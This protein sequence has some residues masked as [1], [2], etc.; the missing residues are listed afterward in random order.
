MIL[1][2]TTGCVG[3]VEDAATP[4]TEFVDPTRNEFQFKGIV[5]SRA[6]SNSKVEL[7][8]VPTFGT[9]DYEYFLHPNGEEGIK[10]NMEDLEESIKGR[11]AYT[12][13]GLEINQLYKFKISAQKIDGGD[14]SM[15][16]NEVVVSTFPNWTANFE[17]VQNV[18]LVPGQSD[19]KVKVTWYNPTFIG[20]LDPQSVD[21]VFY[22]LAIIR[23]ADGGEN[24]KSDLGSTDIIYRRIPSNKSSFLSVSTPPTDFIVDGLDADTEYYFRLRAIHKSWFTDYE[25]KGGSKDLPV[26]DDVVSF[27][28]ELNTRLFKIKTDDSLDPATFVKNSLKV[29]RPD[30]IL[31][32]T[33]LDVAWFQA[34]GL[35]KAY[36]LFY[37]KFIPVDPTDA[38]NEVRIADLLD[39]QYFADFDTNS[40]VCEEKPVDGWGCIEL[41]TDVTSY[42]IENLEEFNYYQVRIAVCLDIA[43]SVTENMPSS[44]IISD[45]A[46]NRTEA[47]LAPFAGIDFINHPQDAD[48]IDPDVSIT[49]DFDPPALSKGYADT[50]T[51]HCLDPVQVDA[52]VALSTS[53]KMSNTMP[54]QAIDAGVGNCDGINFTANN[55]QLDTDT[56]QVTVSGLNDVSDGYPNSRYCFA[57]APSIELRPEQKFLDQSNWVVR[58]INP[59]IQVPTL[60][61]FAGIKGACGLN[62]DQA[63]VNWDIPSGGIF[64]G[65]RVM[66]MVKNGGATLDY[67]YMTDNV[68]VD[69]IEIPGVSPVASLQ[70]DYEIST[71]ITDTTQTSFTITDLLPGRT[72]EVAVLASVTTQK[73]TPDEKTIYSEY[74]AGVV[75][76]DVPLPQARFNEWTRIFA[77]GP[78][79]DGL[80]PKINPY[81]QYEDDAHEWESLN[82]D[83]IPYEVNMDLSSKLPGKGGSGVIDYTDKIFAIPPGNYNAMLNPADAGELKEDNFEF[84]TVIDGRPG[85]FLGALGT[86]YASR[87]GI[88]SLA[89]KD[90][91]LEFADANFK[92]GQDVEEDKNLDGDYADATNR[93][94]RAYG[95][96]VYRSHDNKK[97]WIEVTDKSGLLHAA[98]Y[99]YYEGQPTNTKTGVRMV[100]FTDYSVEYERSLDKYEYARTYW[101]KIVPVFDDMELPQYADDVVGNYAHNT[102]R[103]TLPPANMA[104]VHRMM[105]NRRGCQELGKTM[106]KTG[107]TKNAHYA[108]Q[109]NGVGSKPNPENK[110][111]AIDETYFD[112]GGDLLVDRYELGCN[113]TRGNKVPD[114]TTGRSYIDLT[115]ENDQGDTNL[116]SS[117]VHFKGKSLVG[118][119]FVGCASKRLSSQ[120]N[121]GGG[122]SDY[123][124]NFPNHTR[125]GWQ[126]VIWGDC[127][128]DYD[129]PIGVKVWPETT[130]GACPTN[131][132][133]DESGKTT[134]TKMGLYDYFKKTSSTAEANCNKTVAQSVADKQ[135]HTYEALANLGWQRHY[136]PQ[137]EHLA[138]MKSNQPITAGDG[139]NIPEP[140]PN[141]GIYKNY[142]KPQQCFINLASIGNHD[143][144]GGAPAND[145]T[146]SDSATDYWRSRWIGTS[147]NN[148]DGTIA[149]NLKKT[150]AKHLFEMTVDDLKIDSELYNTSEFKWPNAGAVEDPA[151][152]A[153]RT[154]YVG[155]TKVGEIFSSNSAHLPPLNGYYR[156]EAQ[157]LC[158]IREVKTGVSD[159]MTFTAAGAAKPKRL[160]RKTEFHVAAAWP[161][162]QM[163]D[164]DG[165]DYSYTATDISSLESRV[166]GTGCNNSNVLN[167]NF[168]ADFN[169]N[170]RYSSNTALINPLASTYFLSGSSQAFDGHINRAHSGNC[171]SKYG[172]QDLVG[173]L[174]EVTPE[175]LVC[176]YSVDEMK[177]GPLTGYFKA[178][179][180]T[181]DLAAA[182]DITKSTTNSGANWQTNSNYA[183]EYDVGLLYTGCRNT[184]SNQLNTFI[185]ESDCGQNFNGIMTGGESWRY[186]DKILKDA[187]IMWYVW[188]PLLNAGAGDWALDLAKSS[189]DVGG[190]NQLWWIPSLNS[191]FCSVTDRDSYLYK[192]KGTFRDLS[193]DM[194]FPT[195]LFSGALNASMLTF[196]NPYNDDDFFDMYRDGDG[197]FMNFGP[198][199]QMV[200]LGFE[201]SL[202]ISN[203]GGASAPTSDQG[204][205]KYFNP[206]VGFPLGCGSETPPAGGGCGDSEDNKDFGITRGATSIVSD[207]FVGNSQI[208]NKGLNGISYSTLVDASAS[209]DGFYTKTINSKN[210]SNGNPGEHQV[211][212]SFRVEERTYDM[213][214]GVFRTL[215]KIVVNRINWY[216]QIFDSADPDSLN[217]ISALGTLGDDNI[218]IDVEFTEAQFDIQRGTSLTMN[219]GGAYN[220]TSAGRYTSNINQT[221]TTE[222]SGSIRCVVRINEE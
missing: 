196:P 96:R 19:T 25:N 45:K 35:F 175:R 32:F 185:K 26:N 77:I 16:E 146:I 101:Y 118:N 68:G 52:G 108:C 41:G 195:Q 71:I 190:K 143:A 151:M 74:N 5:A 12:V 160:I 206:V 136:T 88:V 192:Q 86:D 95:Y 144:T 22:E 129:E 162:N 27:A 137:G 42:R 219:V 171:I 57:L 47:D 59:E 106:I 75:K 127:S 33:S 124:G 132:S 214:G 116:V 87:N 9:D 81:H 43:C 115:L 213:G 189:T 134:W 210:G 21:P 218:D 165:T 15:S 208:Y 181:F 110:L 179:G 156:D 53:T 154:R 61:E 157:K 128:Y 38:A 188:D 158:N 60:E 90:V 24:L 178:G 10:L 121:P 46:Y 79:I 100:F 67:D 139:N 40:T 73:G 69:S 180:A 18:A 92:N 123:T 58:C 133:G 176:D 13:R 44:A 76:C 150:N 222:T 63:T 138:V 7:E 212:D 203:K 174:H 202:Y 166:I 83:G 55:G 211:I 14:E 215:E 91:D 17:G 119:N 205:G 51:L 204:V 11:L 186:L 216:D 28:R 221:T 29:E 84:S 161:E 72:Y 167:T 199:H 31:A 78:K 85:M 125:Y 4:S 117:L 37:K 66:W 93:S 170:D 30:G 147:I 200:G 2:V 194:F 23:L 105:A 220:E 20:T 140:G 54:F 89:W 120:F 163:I 131:A 149:G 169:L 197:L 130:V 65:F 80:V 99:D 198:R 187:P 3:T 62:Q 126:S 191:G 168:G 193:S 82:R 8:F 36:R 135:P 48:D 164:S 173:N 122:G 113:F 107:V 94:D 34:Q 103:V 109:Y 114:F 209:N 70:N 141:G 155:T 183:P 56:T 102:I 104:L 98:P 39:T 145:I 217:A 153:G 97:T 184:A 111:N 49:I 207:Y 50:M 152:G 182:I 6:I 177:Y 1:A 64:N 159:G 201:G 112:Q 142:W 172:I 148:T